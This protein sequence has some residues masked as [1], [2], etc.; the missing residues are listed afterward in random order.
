[1]GHHLRHPRNANSNGAARAWGLRVTMHQAT[2][3]QLLQQPQSQPP[4][5]IRSVRCSRGSLSPLPPPHC[6]VLEKPFLLSQPQALAR[7]R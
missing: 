4:E 3:P 2:T 6:R 5:P 1:M 7:V